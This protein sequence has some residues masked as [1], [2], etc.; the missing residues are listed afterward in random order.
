MRDDFG[1]DGGKREPR[2]P[3]RERRR[4]AAGFVFRVHHDTTSLQQCE[5]VERR[6]IDGD[7]ETR[8][9]RWRNMTILHHEIGLGN[10]RIRPDDAET[11][12]EFAGRH[13]MLRRAAGVEVRAGRSFELG[14]HGEP[15]AIDLDVRSFRDRGNLARRCDAAMLVELDAEHVGRF[16]RNDRVRVLDRLAGFVRHQ[17]HAGRGAADRG[18]PCEVRAFDRLFEIVDAMVPQGLQ[19]LQRFR[20]RSIRCW[21][22]CR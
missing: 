12:D 3:C 21:G 19:R 11:E 22:P 15:S 18:H 2:C 20:R 10:Q 1:R 16:C 6:L 9:A 17:R 5:R 13:D 8:T 7:A 4:D 14:Q